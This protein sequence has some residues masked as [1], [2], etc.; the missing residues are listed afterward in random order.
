MALTT[1]NQGL[2]STLAQYTGF[3][4]RIINGGAAIAQRGNVNVNQAAV[5][6][7]GAD[8]II[9]YP[10]YAGGGTATLSQAAVTWSTSGFAQGY[11]AASATGAGQVLFI[12]RIETNNCFDLIGN[13]V[14]VS[15]K[16]AHDFGSACNVQVQLR[17]PSTTNNDFS[18]Q[19]TVQEFVTIGSVPSGTS[20][21][22]YLTFTS[23]TLTS[24]DVSKGLQVTVAINTGAT[25]SSKNFYISD[26]QLEKGSTATAFDYRPF[27][28]E[29]QLCQRYYQPFRSTYETT[30]GTTGTITGTITSFLTAM[31]ASPTMTVT[32]E[33]GS[34]GATLNS[35]GTISTTGSGVYAYAMSLTISTS[36]YAYRYVTGNASA[37]L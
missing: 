14:T 3:K 21:G 27:G 2:L 30:L 34:G 33:E 9:G 32:A 36:G 13:T 1:V 19:T 10:N 28:T 4:N 15:F 11:T 16:V 18:S 22:T 20:S 6:Y 5:A 8:R 37:E 26:W 25:Y 23:N 24:T 17:R 12:H 31:R 7:G 29:L 35:M